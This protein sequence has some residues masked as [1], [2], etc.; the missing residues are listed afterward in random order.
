MNAFSKPFILACI[1]A[2]GFTILLQT[3]CKDDEP[4]VTTEQKLM[5]ELLI[6]ENFD[7][8]TTKQLNIV[9]QDPLK[10]GGSAR[11]DVFLHSTEIHNDTVTFINDE[12]VSVTEIIPSYDET[13]DLIASKITETG[14][15]N[16]VVSIPAY[17]TEL[18]VIK[19]MQGVFTSNTIQVNGSTAILK[20]GFKNSATVDDILYG[21]NDSGKLFTIDLTT[22]QLTTL[23]TLPVGSGACAIDNINNKLYYVGK[24]PP[25]RLYKYDL[26]TQTNQTVAS[27]NMK[28]ERFD[29]NPNDGLLYSCYGERLY[30][31]DPSNGTVLTQKEI[32]DLEGNEF[33]DL[34]ISPEKKWYLAT[35]KG[36]YWLEFKT[37]KVYAHEVTRGNLPFKCTGMTITSTGEMW[38]STHNSNS[39]LVKMNKA[40]GFW[41]YKFNAYNQKIDDLSTRTAPSVPV[42]IDTD[43]D[44]VED[45]YDE[46]PNDALRAYNTYTPSALSDATLAFEDN[47]PKQGDYD[48]N[49]LIVKYRFKTVMN[50]N[51][52]VVELIGKFT[53]AHIG[54]V[55]ENGFGFQLPLSE[56][57]ISSVTGSNITQGLVNLNSK[58]L[59]TGQNKATIVVFDKA[60]DNLYLERTITIALQTPLDAATVGTPPFNP[61]I[62][63]DKD[64][65]R[66][67]HQIN[68]TPTNKMNSA[69]FNTQDDKSNSSQGKFYQTTNK[70]PWV[71]N[72]LETFDFPKEMKPINQAYTKFNTWAESGGSNYNDW[73]KDKPGYRNA[74]YLSVE[75]K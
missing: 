45:L 12:G 9:F 20:G 8:E 22:G 25:Y 39:K 42:V 24:L 71:I 29:Y 16:L 14:L 28:V 64:R 53:V 33:G 70:L 32:E 63:I 5:G 46:Y 43:G 69:L 27:L 2:V 7:F 52:K 3:S 61:F 10:S 51:D 47:W 58:G 37:N 15:F 30:T 1:F 65:G 55:F 68:Q 60:Q 57:Q 74:T 18:Y 54:G 72:F 62:F 13:N 38:I 23:T 34:A 31:I 50:A 73:Y 49:D 40:N 59:E 48:F 6:P 35:Y 56:S 21:V 44:G 75:S 36:V 66:E 41:E 4:V 26:V 17:I 11:Y 67:V 19:N